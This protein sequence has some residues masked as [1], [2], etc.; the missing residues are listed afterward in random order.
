MPLRGLSARRRGWAACATAA[1]VAAGLL[2]GPAASAR[3]APDPSLTTMSIKSP[4]GGANVRVLIFY[5]SA[6]AGEE[7][8]VVNAGIAAIERIGLSGPAKEQFTV[9]A[10]D[11]ANVF[12]NE[13]KLGR[14]NAV[15]FLTG[16][17][18]VLT[19]AQEAGLEAYMEAGGGFVGVHDAARAE[20]YSD[21]FTGLVGARPAAGSPTKVQRA[22][23]EV[24][25]R[26]HPAT[27]DLPL[28]WKRPDEW[29]NW[30][31]NP[32]G[33][34]HTVARVRESTY[35]PGASANGADHPVSWC[36]D[37]DGGRSF[38]T[39]MGGT[40][41][42][43]DE[44]DFRTHLRGALMWTTRISQA[45][46]KAT[47][48]ANY[49]AERLTDPNQPGQNDQIGE[50]HG[51]VTAPD[52]RVFYIGRGGTDSSHPVVTDWN[53]PNVGKGTGEVHVWD[54]K[55]VS[56]AATDEGGSGVERIEYAIGAD[57][58]WQ[59]Y[60]TPV[61]VDQVGEHVVRYRAFD[62]AGNAAE[63]KS[64]TFAV[65]APDTDD[66]TAPETSATVS[67][68]KNA[69]GAYID[70]ATVTVTASDT[71]SG[72]NTIEYA[73]GDG[74]WTAYTAP[75]MVHEVGE[76]TV[77]YRATDKAGN[78]AVEK[79]VAFTVVAAPPQDTT[80]PVTGATV[81]GTKNSDG[82]YV[83]SAKVTVNATDE[84]G[85]GVAG[86]EYSLDAG[87]YLAYTG[88]VVVDRVGRHRGLPGERQGGQH[89]PAADREL[90][91]GGRRGPRAAL[92]GV[93]RAPHGDRRHGRLGGAEP[94]HQQPVPDQRDDRGRKGVDVPGPLPQARP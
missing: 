61:V 27:K 63:E 49:K 90:L 45:D 74:A 56:I 30:Q 5:G 69:D 47:I 48:N 68:E 51:L 82:A 41:S 32:S 34:V 3:P 19:P 92:P 54:P 58:A 67:G 37:Y 71:G 40:V 89:L 55:T 11:N 14:F 66:T 21:W 52:G 81:D 87:P 59:P 13:K 17:G 22:T 23:V 70:M 79:S 9:E 76:H 6:A 60:T 1:F 88:P 72:V 39:G 62:K 64:V 84:G 26:R 42:S 53:D 18:D 16:G 31:K 10:T 25:D 4:P 33:E 78:V 43:Y 77:R 28:E 86:V 7:S 80:P 50:P 75:V 73:V 91:G 15:V 38:Y 94:G 85:S 93:R 83:G 2:A 44:A 65:A 57:G 46:C 12:T 35:A 8:P 20:P 24:G 29:L 36:R